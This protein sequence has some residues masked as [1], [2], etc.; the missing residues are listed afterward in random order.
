MLAHQ[1]P[2]LPSLDDLLLRLPNLIR[3]IDEPSVALPASMLV[4]PPVKRDGA[5]YAPAGIQY[6]GSGQP[7]E[8]IR[9]AGMNRLL[10]E[11]DYHGRRRLAEPYSLSTASTGN[12]LFYGWELGGTH[13]KAF[14]VVNMGNVRATNTGFQPRYQIEFTPHGFLSAPSSTRRARTQHFSSRSSGRRRATSDPVYI[15]ECSHCG[16]KFGHRKNDPELRKHKAKGADYDCAGRHG[17]L[18]DTRY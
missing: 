15:F 17:Y 18:V 7:L 8:V 9:F 12:L 1:L 2:A 10:V 13:I 3:W 5:L 16:K 11:F 6:S 4:A 14:K